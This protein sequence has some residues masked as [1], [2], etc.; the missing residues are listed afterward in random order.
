[1]AISRWL[2]RAIVSSIGSWSGDGST[3]LPSRSISV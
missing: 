1:M 2:L 3:T